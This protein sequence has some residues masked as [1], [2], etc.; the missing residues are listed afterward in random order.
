MTKSVRESVNAQ[1]SSCGNE[2][3]EIKQEFGFH[4]NDRSTQVEA[5]AIPCPCKYCT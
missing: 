4:E 1:E 2:V 3:N 5:A